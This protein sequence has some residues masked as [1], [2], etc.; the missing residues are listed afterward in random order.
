M[1][2]IIRK[3]KDTKNTMKVRTNKPKVTTMKLRDITK[4]PTT[5]AKPMQI[6]TPSPKTTDTSKIMIIKKVT[7]IKKIM[8]INITMTTTNKTPTTNPKMRTINSKTIKRLLTK[9]S[10]N[11]KERTT[12]EAVEYKI[13]K[14]KASITT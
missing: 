4:N 11:F 9:K 1:N 8:T 7:F 12:I 10:K 3:T 2:N 6:K 13:I 5:T 14:T